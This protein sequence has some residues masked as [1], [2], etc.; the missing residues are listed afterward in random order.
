MKESNAVRAIFFFFF[1]VS[2]VSKYFNSEMACDCQN[3]WG[4]L[5]TYSFFIQSTATFHIAMQ[6]IVSLHH[7]YQHNRFQEVIWLWSR[8]FMF[9][10][11]GAWLAVCLSYRSRSPCRVCVCVRTHLLPGVWT[12]RCSLLCCQNCLSGW[13]WTSVYMT[14]NDP[15]VIPLYSRPYSIIREGRRKWWR[16]QE[17]GGC[18]K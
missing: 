3:S 18:R 11:N 1:V 14:A 9:V 4:V 6:S 16:G 8:I 15:T 13:R 5:P 2:C 10:F 12:L 17:G 7:I